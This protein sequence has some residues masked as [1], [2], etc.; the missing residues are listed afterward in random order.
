MKKKIKVFCPLVQLV[1]DE[2]SQICKPGI[3][4]S[5]K[6]EL[7]E[8]SFFGFKILRDQAWAKNF[9]ANGGAQLAPNLEGTFGEPFKEKWIKYQE[10]E[11]DVVILHSSGNPDEFKAAA[12]HYKHL[13]IIN[14][15]YKDVAGI[16]KS[17]SGEFGNNIINNR[18]HV[19]LGK[20]EN[21]FNFKRS[22][23]KMHLGLPLEFE[24]TLYEIH[25]S[26]YCVR[27]D[28]LRKCEELSVPYYKRKFDISCF[29][30]ESRKG[31]TINNIINEHPRNPRGWMPSVVASLKGFN[32]HVGFTT[33]NN[34]AP[35]Q[36][37]RAGQK[38]DIV[39]ST[40]YKYAQIMSNSKI[41][42]TACPCN[43]EGDFRLMEAMTSG[44]LVMHNY[45]LR[46]PQGLENGKHWIVYDNAQD[47]AEKICFYNRYPEKAKQIA[48]AGKDLVIKN[49]RSHHRV[50]EWLK[51][52]GLI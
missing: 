26:P 24:K 19:D 32:S 46:P 4:N 48:D 33:G 21:I 17:K 13:P 10:E 1:N 49:H 35:A 44:A 5:D 34:K 52:A 16:D 51:I 37:G 7:V 38:I 43:Y 8:S 36:E 29:F 18:M 47:L 14:I 23:T 42:A 3:L 28:I 40:Q 6:C 27:E 41:I 15:D 39:G 12:K 9:K 20:E 2:V 22:L 45:M 25:H 11:I 50:E 31:Y 30:P